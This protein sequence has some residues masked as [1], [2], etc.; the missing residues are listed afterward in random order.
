MDFYNL[1]IK[2]SAEKELRKFVPK[3]D[4]LRIVKKIQ[5]LKSDPRPQGHEKL[6]GEEKFRVRQ[7][8]WRIVYKV[9]DLKKIVEIVKIGHRREVYRQI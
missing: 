5:S 6:S 3:E 9:D 8:N 7:G 4:L 1:W 2:R